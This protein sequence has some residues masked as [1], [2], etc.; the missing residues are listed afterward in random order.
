MDAVDLAERRARAD[1]DGRFADLLHELEHLVEHTGD[2]DLRRQVVMA[3]RRARN[4]TEK[5][6]VR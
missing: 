5:E 4:S 6:N 3:L 2:H 1:R